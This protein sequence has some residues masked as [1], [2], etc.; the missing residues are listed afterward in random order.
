M[1]SLFDSLPQTYFYAKDTEGSQVK[2]NRL[3]LENHGLNDKTDALAKT[4]YDPMPSSFS[5]CSRDPSNHLA[6]SHATLPI[7]DQK[8]AISRRRRR[9]RGL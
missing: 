6:V 7:I 9:Q 2:V 5:A 1:I 3:F 4:D 8:H